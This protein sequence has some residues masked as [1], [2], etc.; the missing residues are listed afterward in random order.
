MD[1]ESVTLTC[2]TDEGKY[3]PGKITFRAKEGKSINLGKIQESITATRLSG[4]TNMRVDYLEITVRGNLTLHNGQPIL[5]VAGAEQQFDLE[6]DD[7]EL[8]KRLRDAAGRSEQSVTVVGSVDGWAGRF[9]VVL[10][11]FAKRYGTDGSKPI[12]LVI[13][14]LEAAEDN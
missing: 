3:R 9:P 5:Q 10:R 2:E 1:S 8:E 7:R 6:A 4:N 12:L 13:T 11:T 14:K